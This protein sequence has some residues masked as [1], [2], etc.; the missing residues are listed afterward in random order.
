VIAPACVGH[1]SGFGAHS[2]LL[3]VQAMAYLLQKPA[4]Q[5]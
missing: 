4:E 5:V 3:A 2:Y 1:I